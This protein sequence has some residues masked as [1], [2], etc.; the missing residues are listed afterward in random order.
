MTTA[1]Q[2]K[3]TGSPYP[4]DTGFFSVRLCMGSGLSAEGLAPV[5]TAWDRGKRRHILVRAP[6]RP[7][8]QAL[9]FR[10]TRKLGSTTV[11]QHGD[12]DGRMETRARR[13]S[14]LA[15]CLHQA[16]AA[17]IFE[18]AR[19]PGPRNLTILNPPQ[20]LEYYFIRIRGHPNPFL[21]YGHMRIV[22][23]MPSRDRPFRRRPSAVIARKSGVAVLSLLHW[24]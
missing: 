5:G 16:K 17:Q 13:D 11:G 7:A 12:V 20:R 9:L 1:W 14:A 15:H 24:N 18:N 4:R 2:Q 21:R 22:T 19:T 10:K 6:L 3:Y 23:A 8:K